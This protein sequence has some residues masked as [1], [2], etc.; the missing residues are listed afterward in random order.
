MAALSFSQECGMAELLTKSHK[1]DSE[2]VFQGYYFNLCC[3]SHHSITKYEHYSRSYI[4]NSL[5][6][7]KWDRNIYTNTFPKQGNTHL[8][9]CLTAI[10][11]EKY[12]PHVQVWTLSV[13]IKNV[14]LEQVKPRAH[15]S[16]QLCFFLPRSHV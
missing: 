7:Y 2:P 12:S 9:P 10:S 13:A 15:T 1:P 4:I 16:V 8:K 6:S 14:E 11:S 5:V 3:L